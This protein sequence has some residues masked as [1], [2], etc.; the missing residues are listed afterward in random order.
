MKGRL[1]EIL[2]VE[3][4]I[5]ILDSDEAFANFEKTTK[6]MVENKKFV[7]DSAVGFLQVDSVS[8]GQRARAASLLRKVAGQTDSPRLALIAVSAELDAFTKVKEIIDK[9]IGELKVQQADEV[10]HRDWCIDEFATN[11]EEIQEGDHKMENL[12]QRKSDLETSIEE[13]KEAIKRL[14]EEMA[15]SQKQMGRA[16]DVREAEAADLQTTIQDQRL[17]QVILN[18]ALLRMK[19]VYAL[20]QEQK[21]GAAHVATSATHTDAGNAPARFTKYEQN[22]GGNRVVQLLEIVIKDSQAIEDEALTQDLN[23]QV[24]YE[25]FMKASNKELTQNIETKAGLEESMAKAH[26]DLVATKED[27]MDLLRVLEG[28]HNYKGDLHKSCDFILKNFDARQAAR[29]AE[30]EALAE[31][32]A[33]LSGA[34]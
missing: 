10:K 34:K 4:T 15:E 24:E 9:L 5:K 26:K 16:G 29:Q 33:I 18:K 20:L 7:E 25:D 27:I 32:K 19:E 28:L 13:M 14:T 3:E 6:N 2:A 17:T 11:K 8:K 12:Q 22:S 30:M 31:A 21:P 23:S 1:E